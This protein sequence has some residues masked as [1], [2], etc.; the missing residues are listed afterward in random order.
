MRHAPPG[1]M[2][3]RAI[4]LLEVVT[5]M[6][7]GGVPS[8]VLLLLE[9]L[10]RRGYRVT[11]ACAHC[12][13]AHRAALEALGVEVLHIELRRLLSPVADMQALAAL[14]RL[15]RREEFDI[16][17]THMSKAALL[18]GL[19][20]R[21]AGAPVVVNTAHNLGSIALPKAW[22]RALFRVYDK[23]LLSITT[24]TV[25]T[26]TDHVRAEVV[27]RRIVGPS[28]VRAIPNGLRARPP[29][30]E[31]EAGAARN[32]LLADIGAGPQTLVLGSVA[33][34]VWFKGLD[35][36]IAALPSVVRA[37]PQVRLVLVG[38]GPMRAELAQQATAL[39]VHDRVSFL[40]ERQDVERLLPA[41]DVFTLPSVSEGMPMTILEAM[42]A[43]RPVVATSVGGV[44][45]VVADGVTGLLVAPRD[46][47][48]LAAALIRLLG[49]ATLRRA[50]GRSG[51]ERVEAQFTAAAMVSATDQ[52]FR[53]LL[54]GGGR[55]DCLTGAADEKL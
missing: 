32:A 33:R 51:R 42:H 39:G 22:L 48:A 35:A 38:D 34:L 6:D 45:E 36:L 41:F 8:H 13:P 5:R 50:M 46:P 37:C 20:G 2:R 29:V 43:C 53:G 26:V 16:V 23:L 9:G 14:Y 30:G 52:L 18:G 3:G 4:R 40:G 7:V 21:L 17:H 1:P 25:V 15:I 10:C 19:A 49:D 28:R 31:G 47:A 11:L 24:D 12:T 27:A 54:L 44:P 55:R